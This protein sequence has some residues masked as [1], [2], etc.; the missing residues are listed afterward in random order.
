VI[1]WPEKVEVRRASRGESE[2]HPWRLNH[3][4]RVGS[5]CSCRATPSPHATATLQS[6]PCWTG[7]IW[8]SW[9]QAKSPQDSPR[10]SSDRLRSPT[11]GAASGWPGRDASGTCLHGHCA[12]SPRDDRGVGRSLLSLSP[13][14]QQNGPSLGPRTCIDSDMPS[15][16]RAGQSAYPVLR[17]TSVET[18]GAPS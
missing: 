18:A 15:D 5:G 8:A 11:H 13:R 6:A 9:P 10:W 3:V 17:A 4:R 12:C 1:R 2:D 16:L 7:R 14:C